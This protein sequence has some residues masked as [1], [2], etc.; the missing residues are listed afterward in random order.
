M[1]TDYLEDLRGGG[2]RV[3]TGRLTLDASKA[4][5]KMQEFTLS[6]PHRYV[7]Q[8]VR[9]ASIAGADAVEFEIDSDEMSATFDRRLDFERLADLWRMGLEHPDTAEGVLAIGLGSANA[10]QPAKILVESSGRGRAARLTIEG[11]V[12]DFVR[13]R[14]ATDTVRT[15]IYV[16]EKFRLGHLAEWF[17]TTDGMFDEVRALEEGCAWSPLKVVVNGFEVACPRDPHEEPGPVVEFGG[18]RGS[19]T[20]TWSTDLVV[21]CLKQGVEIGTYRQPM[22]TYGGEGWVESDDFPTDLTFLNAV[23]D[24]EFRGLARTIGMEAYFASLARSLADRPTSRK[25]GILR[26]VATASAPSAK[27]ILAALLQDRIWP[28]GC[29]GEPRLVSID[30]VTA[31]GEIRWVAKEF[32]FESDELSPVMCLPTVSDFGESRNELLGVLRSAV[33]AKPRD[34]TAAFENEVVRRANVSRWKAEP[35]DHGPRG[36]STAEIVRDGRTISA[37]VTALLESGGPARTMRRIEGRTLYSVD[38]KRG[39]VSVDLDGSFRADARFEDYHPEERPILEELVLALVDALPTFVEELAASWVDEPG[40]RPLALR[41]LRASADGMFHIRTVLG[42]FEKFPESRDFASSLNEVVSRHGLYR[43]FGPVFADGPNEEAFDRLGSLA[44]VRTFETTRGF[45]SVREL[46]AL[47]HVDWISRAAYDRGRA[48]ESAATM[49]FV[50][51][52]ALLTLQSLFGE[53]CRDGQEVL[54][55]EEGRRRF[56]AK[57]QWSAPEGEPLASHEFVSESTDAHVLARLTKGQGGTVVEFVREGRVLGTTESAHV[58]PGSVTITI[59]DDEV[60]PDVDWSD[61]ADDDRFYDLLADAEKAHIEALASFVLEAGQVANLDDPTHSKLY[62]DALLAL[63]ESDRDWSRR[64]LL[65]RASRED[66][67][68]VPRPVSLEEVREAVRGDAEVRLCW[69][70]MPTHEEPG[71]LTVYVGDRPLP[72]RTIGAIFGDSSIL[73]VSPV[74]WDDAT[75][76]REFRALPTT[77]FELK[78]VVASVAVEA[79]DL[80]VLLGVTY[81]SFSTHHRAST[82][83]RILF[84]DRV[85]TVVEAPTPLGDFT[86]IAR[87]RGIH[88][89]RTMSHVATGAAGIGELVLRASEEVVSR[90]LDEFSRAPQRG[91]VRDTLLKCFVRVRSQPL[92]I[93]PRLLRRMEEAP[94]FLTGDDTWLSLVDLRGRSVDGIVHYT[95]EPGDPDALFVIGIEEQTLRRLLG[96]EFF[97]VDTRDAAAEEVPLFAAAVDGEPALKETLVPDEE[98]ELPS[99]EEVLGSRARPVRTS[100][101]ST[102]FAPRQVS[103]VQRVRELVQHASPTA[104]IEP[105]TL[106]T[107]API[108]RVITDQV[109]LNLEHPVCRRIVEDPSDVAVAFVASMVVTAVNAQ[110]REVLDVDEAKSQRRLLERI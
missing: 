103:F 5:Q 2:E 34:C 38:Q 68:F 50:D 17:V 14:S 106:G 75:A 47:D 4:R 69:G 6:N 88:P 67:G 23:Q 83:T 62:F 8:I 21:H 13:G 29:A 26:D 63:V 42:V 87:G 27:K 45:R 37:S 44:E 40:V 52:E 18:G 19:V 102:G 56:L 16:R 33:V 99:V 85:L 49:V 95:F 101:F 55:R 12:D 15:R 20:V 107:K 51:D 36:P 30:D 1:S 22:T 48:A 108:C 31:N 32:D 74:A 86:A 11:G 80:E 61:V 76:F 94:L 78:D 100:S 110:L 41:W 60:Q 71:A 43:V 24:A 79:G 54:R 10:L 97:L 66:E 105:A 28:R 35:V 64:G 82:R 7:L 53:R 25:R 104:V 96:E 81:S 90:T 57:P 89:D 46:A 92:E 65:T 91:L 77:A 73:D 98:I 58:L 72:E 84:D 39:L 9:C 59:F 3:A 109:E 93:P 70:G